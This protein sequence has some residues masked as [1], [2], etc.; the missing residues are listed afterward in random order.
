MKASDV[1]QEIRN[2]LKPIK[3]QGQS[4]FSIEAMENYL[5]LFAKDVENDTFYKSQDHEERLAKFKA[6]NDRSIALANNQT[7]HSL[8]MFKSVITA[9]QSALKSGM[10]ING[11]AA[12]ALLAFAGKIWETAISEVV[13]NSL[14]SSIFIFC[15]GVLSAAL[16]TGTTYLSQLLFSND[17]LKLGN[18]V[19]R[20]NIAVVLSSYGFFCF[21]AYKAAS[22][23]GMHFGL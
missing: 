22:S 23:L 14:T 6:E 18:Y 1:L 15:L 13:A 9:G 12:V 8:E 20:F 16:A 4:T 3:E 5:N 2:A 7:A 10:V 19:N 11:G 21:G 17:R